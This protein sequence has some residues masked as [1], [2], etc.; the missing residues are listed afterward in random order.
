MTTQTI[1]DNK[2]DKMKNFLIRAVTSVFIVAALV[3]SFVLR[4]CVDERWMYLLFFVFAA[5]SSFEMVRALK[6]R[7]TDFTKCV[8]MAYSLAIVPFYMFFGTSALLIMTVGA[9]IL[10][11]LATV[12]DFE[13]TT[14]EKTAC[15]F[16]AMF[17]PGVLLIPML[18]AN[19]LENNSFIALLL[20]FSISPVADAMAYVVGSL[21]KGPKLCTKINQKK[22][23]SGAIGGL[24]GG[25]IVSVVVW[26]AYA[27]GK[28]LDN[29]TWEL[30]L[31]IVTGLVGALFTELGDLVES[32]I[33]RKLEIKDMGRILPGHGGMLDRIDG[34]MLCAAFIYAVFAFIG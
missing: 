2:G 8:V 20:I 15:G 21:L 18:L 33:K 6:D 13:E 19:S 17:Y 34:N 31:F 32:A 22:T 11:L 7:L 12:F 24:L 14:I 28:V 25:I 23:V 4:Q 9:G 16:F 5:L 30:V 29:A 3:G 26:L 1:A 10:L 27:K